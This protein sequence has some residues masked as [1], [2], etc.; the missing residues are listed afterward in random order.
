MN[1]KVN[2]NTC[3]DSLRRPVSNKWFAFIDDEDEYI[4]FEL[5]D[6]KTMHTS[7]IYA[8]ST[9]LVIRTASHELEA[10]FS[11]KDKCKAVCHR[12][13]MHKYN[14]GIV[15]ST[16]GLKAE[17]EKLQEDPKEKDTEA[18]RI[19]TLLDMTVLDFIHLIGWCSVRVRNGIQNLKTLRELLSSSEAE[20]LKAANFGR[21]S[22][23]DLKDMIEDF[24][25]QHKV[26][27]YLGMEGI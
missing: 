7:S 23:E 13:T 5:N 8:A 2:L 20:L 1:T 18:K 6:L 24:N 4:G 14:A 16:G 25:E 21:K 9:L 15:D 19:N 11:S 3:P 22:L 17:L 12:I 10:I 27:F 26:N